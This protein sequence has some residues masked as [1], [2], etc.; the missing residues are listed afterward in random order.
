[1]LATGEAHATT[2]R[3][4]RDKNFSIFPYLAL[5][6]AG[7]SVHPPYVVR[8][9]SDAGAAA[10]RATRMLDRRQTVSASGHYSRIDRLTI[11][12]NLDAAG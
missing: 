3:L 9:V 7:A 6:D 12:S 10:A 4:R 1:M 5:G 8:D 2:A 11:V